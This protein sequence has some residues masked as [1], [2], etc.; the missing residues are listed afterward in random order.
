MK[1]AL[2]LCSLALNPSSPSPTASMVRISDGYCQS[3]GGTFCISVPVD[4]DIGACFSPK[5]VAN[6]YR[7]ERK[8]VS[9]KLHK[10][11]LVLQEGK[12]KLS[13]PFLAVDEMV[14]L[15]VISKPRPIK[16]DTTHIKTCVDI[17]DPAN[18]RIWAQGISFRYGMMEATNN[19]IVV[20]AITDFNDDIEFN[21]PVAS[22]KALL[23]FKSPITHIATDQRAVKFIHKDGS[24]L[25][26]LSICEQM[27]ETKD[28]Y[29][30]EWTPLGL[31]PALAKDLLSIE[32]EDLKFTDGIV[33]YS[34]GDVVGNIELGTNT[35]IAV[36]VGKE[37]F[38][39]LIR[40]SS[41]IMLSDDL[42]RFQ[43]VS[44][45]CRIISSTRGNK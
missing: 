16:F 33:I 3:Y 24:S 5:A 6:F 22:A 14:T 26:S 42:Y 18:S 12:E 11:K 40:L 29:R 15:D 35:D 39:A 38:D 43:A 27:I 20:S 2:Q 4:I 23:K 10:N 17:I 8:A 7:K 34:D 44:A 19:S 13:I 36:S 41:D 32:C 28:F 9:F 45:T 1:E 30:G 31:K 37:N 25:T 21:L